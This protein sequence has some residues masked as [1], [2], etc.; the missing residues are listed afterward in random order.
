MKVLAN[1]MM[2]TNLFKFLTAS[3]AVRAMLALAAVA[4]PVQAVAQTCAAG[5]TA[6]TLNFAT[7][8]WTQGAMSQTFNLGSG[9]SAITI[10]GTFTG[11]MNTPTWPRYFPPATGYGFHGLNWQVNYSSAAQTTTLAWTFSKTITNLSFKVLD[12]DRAIVGSTYNDGIAFTTNGPLGNIAPTITPDNPAKVEVAGNVVRSVQYALG[13]GNEC[14][15]ADT[16][17]NAGVAFNNYLKSVTMVY[18]NFPQ[19]AA[20]ANPATQS[21]G[22]SSMSFCIAPDPDL[23]SGK[24]A[25]VATA[26]VDQPFNFNL[27]AANNTVTGAAPSSGVVTVTDTINAANLTINSITPASGWSCTPTTGFPITSGSVTV[28]CTSSANIMKATS[29]PVATIN[30]TP[31][32]GAVPSLSNTVTVSGGGETNTTNNGATITVPV[33]GPEVSLKITK[34]NGTDTVIS[35]GQ[36]TYTVVVTNGGPAAA[37]GATVRD[38]KG[39]GLGACTVTCSSSGSATCPASPGNIMSAD[40]PI[41]SLP[42]GGTVT[43]SVT[44]AVN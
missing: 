37:D 39:A 5:E 2:P 34:S 28:S 23:T 27:T 6:Q 22:M 4:A 33:N 32:V 8:P 21:A 20:S 31:K 24:T 44:C 30:A 35:G 38:T 18:G 7:N 25:S 3:R 11:P 14:G 10:T 17:C 1:G 15:N 29:V 26:N 43:F 41:P 16:A 40:T 13:A 9:A 42:A 36:T 19:S 12:I